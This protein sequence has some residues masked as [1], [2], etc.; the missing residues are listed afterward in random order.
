MKTVRIISAIGAILMIVGLSNGFINGNFS[1]D[2]SL[3]L[4]NPWGIVS[5]V[6]LYVGFVL[7]SMWIVFREKNVVKAVVLV[8]LM[9]VLGFLTGA[10]YV[11]YV[12]FK[13]KTWVQFFFG[14]RVELATHSSAVSS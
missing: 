8:F 5:L 4:S 13:E 10:L 9:M 1:E 3:L 6:D 2:G 11:L 7:F 12:A 14:D